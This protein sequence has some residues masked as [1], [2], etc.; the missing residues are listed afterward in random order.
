VTPPILIAVDPTRPDR[1]SVVL[2]AAIASAMGAPV[3]VAAVYHHERLPTRSGA[4][5]DSFDRE[6][7]DEAVTV[8]NEVAAGLDMNAETHVIGAP[9]RARGLQ[10]LAEKL[11]P[12]ILVLGSTHRGRVGRV[13]IGGTAEHLLHGAPC[14]VAV[15][16]RGLEAGAVTLRRIGV[17]FLE[18]DDGHEALRGAVALARG[19]GATLRLLAVDEQPPYTSSAV[20]PGYGSPQLE[21]MVRE[22]RR[23]DLERAAAAVPGGVVA[24]SVLLD[25]SAASALIE[26][27]EDLDLLVCGSR[28]YGVV[29]R[30]LLGSVSRH[31][32]RS[33]ACPVIVVPRGGAAALERL[34]ETA[35]AEAAR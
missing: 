11:A 12:A 16:P 22:E 27:S 30:V 5:I 20:A 3:A 32:V 1:E 2:G 19:L 15:A 33:A 28:G 29:G 18:T 23:A 34:A 10:D 25:R 8:V 21:H 24:E 31:L 7:R 6:R 13:L 14:P 17:G 4:V 26:A 35:G 9:S